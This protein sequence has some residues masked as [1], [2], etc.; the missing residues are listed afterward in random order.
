[1][2]ILSTSHPNSNIHPN[3]I[4][5]RIA[6]EDTTAVP[7]TI[8]NQTATKFVTVPPPV[9]D[10]MVG[11]VAKEEREDTTVVASVEAT[12]DMVER[13]AKEVKE[14]TMVLVSSKKMLDVKSFVT[15]MTYPMVSTAT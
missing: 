15:S 12:V 7:A 13:E 1:M 9:V 14:D 2:T 5:L 10:P 4:R 6:T 3:V 8:R 11:R